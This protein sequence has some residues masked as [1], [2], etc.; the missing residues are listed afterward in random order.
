[1][2]RKVKGGFTIIE[3]LIAIAVLTTSIVGSLAALAYHSFAAEQSGNYTFAVNYS[4]KLMDLLQSGQIDPLAFAQAGPPAAP[5]SHQAN[6]GTVWLDLD[7]GVLASG[8]GVQDFWGAPGTAERIRFDTEKQKFGV[9]FVANRLLA[10]WNGA[11]VDQRFRNQLVE[12]VVTTRWRNRG[13]FRSVQLRGYYATS[14]S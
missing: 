10:D 7:S 1:M 6:D 8:G 11:P 14:A 9:N 5:D 2:R 13:V 4:R 12:V 3:L